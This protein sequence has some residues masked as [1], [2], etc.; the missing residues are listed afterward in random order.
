MDAENFGY[1][2]Y[3]PSE[4]CCD[5]I[6]WLPFSLSDSIAH[7]AMPPR[8]F[9]LGLIFANI[10]IFL[11]QGRLVPQRRDT[12]FN[13]EKYKNYNISVRVKDDLHW[14]EWKTLTIDI[15][16]VN[17][18]PEFKQRTYSLTMDEET[19]SV[20]NALFIFHFKHHFKLATVQKANN[21]HA[22]LPLEM[23]SF[24]L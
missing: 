5:V 23:Y 4:Y 12:P 3:F 17:E 19:V 20:T 11:F 22:N 7:G 21:H 9:L 10:Y 6:G 24:T 16:D 15:T 13:Y 8:G 14:S 1:V 18:A 2:E